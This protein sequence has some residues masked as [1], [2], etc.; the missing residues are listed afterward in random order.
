MGPAPRPGPRLSSPPGV[1]ARR[2]AETRQRLRTEPLPSARS[3]VAPRALSS[4]PEVYPPAAAHLAPAA[5]AA[6]EPVARP[7]SLAAGGWGRSPTA[8]GV[9]PGGG[10]RSG[11]AGCVWR[12]SGGAE[13]SLGCRSAATLTPSPRL[14][15]TS[16]GKRLDSAAG[17]KKKLLAAGVSLLGKNLEEL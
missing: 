16:L 7:A 6:P 15:R 10:G 17:H 14:S 1:R 4:L 13:G 12:P 3:E 2:L 8:A 11:A 5:C 9:R